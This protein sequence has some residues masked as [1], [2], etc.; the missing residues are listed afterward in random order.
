MNYDANSA[1]AQQRG[2]LGEP[3][4]KTPSFTYLNAC[5]GTE[6]S[7]SHTRY[8]SNL[9]LFENPFI[10]N[11]ATSTGKRGAALLD[12]HK[13][14]RPPA[15]FLNTAAH[16]PSASSRP[17][18]ADA[19]QPAQATPHRASSILPHTAH[20]LGSQPSAPPSLLRRRLT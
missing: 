8:A 11:I 6:A 10:P 14:C 18:R 4:P 9:V 20:A 13:I 2:A 5:A 17:T 1:C 19:I 7:T 3:R 12:P 15:T 16:R